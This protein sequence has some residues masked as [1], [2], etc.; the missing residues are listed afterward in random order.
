MHMQ[1]AR[2][3]APWILA[4]ALVAPLTLSATHAMAAP[5]RERHTAT[6]S[7]TKRAGYHQFSGTVVSIDGSS[8]TV[9][10][11]G[12]T[13]K[14]MVF[15]RA[16]SL[17]PGDDLGKDSRVTVF[18]REEGGKAVAHRVVTRPESGTPR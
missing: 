16:A 13:P 2:R 5:K 8:L 4:A 18:W 1:H 15:A 3:F 9:E 7:S 10:K 14:Q 12:K 17:R 6:T 11:G